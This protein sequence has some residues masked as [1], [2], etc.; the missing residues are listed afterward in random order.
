MQAKKE[1]RFKPPKQRA[2][3]QPDLH[4]ENHEGP[5]NSHL[6]ELPLNRP[7]NTFFA[8]LEQ[9]RPQSL[10]MPGCSCPSLRD[11]NSNTESVRCLECA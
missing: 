11:G 2:V 9:V 6:L 1:K 10:S 4:F 3:I 8:D 5:E 7:A